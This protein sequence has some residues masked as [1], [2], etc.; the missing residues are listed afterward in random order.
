MDDNHIFNGGLI[1]RVLYVTCWVTID[2]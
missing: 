2:V 1:M